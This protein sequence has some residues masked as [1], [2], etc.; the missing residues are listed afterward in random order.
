[1]SDFC[2]SEE[3][4]PVALAESI[5]IERVLSLNFICVPEVLED[6]VTGCAFEFSR[7][8]V[9]DLVFVF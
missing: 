3:V 2:S 9:G 5:H 6:T 1:M 7:G 4:D 8:H